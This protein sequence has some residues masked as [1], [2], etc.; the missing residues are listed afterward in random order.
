MPGYTDKSRRYLRIADE[1][2][3]RA[4]AALSPTSKSMFLQLAKQYR[5]LAEQIDDPAQWRARPMASDKSK[6]GS[7]PTVRRAD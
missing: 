1:H 7:N 4:E 6:K 2:T 5:E 3:Y